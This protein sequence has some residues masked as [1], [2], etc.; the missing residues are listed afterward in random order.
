[1]S[2][3]HLVHLKKPFQKYNIVINRV[4]KQIDVKIDTRKESTRIPF[5]ISDINLCNFLANRLFAC[6]ILAAVNA[7]VN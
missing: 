7:K 6:H 3:K 2:L 4:F 1:M 5:A